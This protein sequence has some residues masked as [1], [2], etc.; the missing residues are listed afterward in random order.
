MMGLGPVIGI[1]PRQLQLLQFICGYQVAHRGK[2][3][4][5][6]ECA[7]GLGLASKSQAHRMLTILEAHGWLRRGKF[8]P[9]DIELL[10][11]VPVGSNVGARLC[12]MPIVS[13][14]PVRFSE[15]RL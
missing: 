2:S 13:A 7:R 15:E 3:P 10:A 1:M 14:R 6:L 12:A 5:L 8:C 11:P 4:S 9:R